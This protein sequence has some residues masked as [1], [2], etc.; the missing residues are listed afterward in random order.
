MQLRIYYE[1]WS[2]TQHFVSKVILKIDM[3]YS[4]D[5]DGKCSYDNPLVLGEGITHSS[6]F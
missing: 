5:Y 3:S 2:T 1:E 6:Y 4:F